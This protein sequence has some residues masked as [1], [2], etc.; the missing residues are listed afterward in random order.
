MTSI[1]GMNNVEESGGSDSSGS[2]TDEIVPFWPTTFKRQ[3]LIMCES[4]YAYFCDLMSYLLSVADF[5]Q[6]TV[7]F[8]AVLIVLIPA[9]SPFIRAVTHSVLARSLT[10]A[11]IWSRAYH[12][13][14]AIGWDSKRIRDN[15]ESDVRKMKEEVKE[16]MSARRLKLS[17]IWDGV[18]G[19][20]GELLPKTPHASKEIINMNR[21]ST[22]TPNGATERSPSD[23]EKGI[24]N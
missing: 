9:F 22:V 11:I 5:I 6:V 4:N 15:T 18:R 13:W 1:F 12:A 21:N 20:D 10:K 23:L 14:L 19:A 16:Q 17:E 2:V 3:I 24:R 8:G 7:S